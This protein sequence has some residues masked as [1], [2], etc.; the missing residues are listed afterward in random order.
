MIYYANP[1]FFLMPTG[2]AYL[3]RSF[4]WCLLSM[5]IHVCLSGFLEI[6]DYSTVAQRYMMSISNKTFMCAHP[7]AYPDVNCSSQYQ[8]CGYPPHNSLHIV[9]AASD[10]HLP[11]PGMLVGL[12]ISSVW[13]WCTDQVRP[14][15]YNYSCS[16]Q[17]VNGEIT[18]YGFTYC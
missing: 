12:T 4:P 9:R 6:G 17:C 14:S 3:Y 15:C 11:W 16:E 18:S 13:Y 1:P 2:I 7:E 5:T 10:P 8:D